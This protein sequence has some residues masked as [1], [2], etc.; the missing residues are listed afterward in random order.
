MGK[1]QNI[2][3]YSQEY[4]ENVDMFGYEVKNAKRSKKKK[5][6]KFKKQEHWEEDSY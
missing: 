5:V 3:T 4:D 1:S 6:N 2:N